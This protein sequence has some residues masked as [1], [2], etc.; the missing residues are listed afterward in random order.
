[1]SC[2]PAV[3]Y[4]D[5]V[6]AAAL[7]GAALK[8]TVHGLIDGHTVVSYGDAWDAL[9]VLDAS[10][11][12]GSR[13]N[14]IYSD[15]THDAITDRGVASG[16][17]REHSWPKS[18]GVGYSGPDYSDLFALYAADWNVNSAR[19]NL[20]FD[21]CTTGCTVPAHSEASAT[22]AKDSLRFQPP[23]DVRGDLARA[24][25]Y[26]AVRYDGGESNT[27]DLE[28]AD[29]PNTTAATMGRL[30]TMLA[31]HAA[32]PVSAAEAARSEGTCGY[33]HNRNPFVDHPE[34]AECI[35]V[36]GGTCANA[37]PYPPASPPVPPSPPSPSP[38]P[39]APPNSCALISGVIDG[40]ARRES[41]PQPPIP[42]ALPV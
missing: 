21:D 17:N 31:W 3:Q 15:H 34:W 8:T 7:G 41:N 40:H 1:M 33:Q 6:D 28:L 38:P 13:V 4:W 11:S 14:M 32:D 16:W 30:S 2:Q 23:E 10:P 19:S 24:Q 5:G 22:T 12:N 29:T 18:Y 35:F 27:E 26:M 25:F 39:V 20:Y 36:D 42:R 37:P 9:S